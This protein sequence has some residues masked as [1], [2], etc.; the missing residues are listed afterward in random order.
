MDCLRSQLIQIQSSQLF[1]R[2]ESNS[3]SVNRQRR[4]LSSSRLYI[5]CIAKIIITR[6][7]DKNSRQKPRT[8][9]LPS[10]ETRKKEPKNESNMRTVRRGPPSVRRVSS[11]NSNIVSVQLQSHIIWYSSAS[12]PS[13]SSSA[14]APIFPRGL[15]PETPEESLL[16]GGK[17]C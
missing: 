6:H 15:L 17:L 3:D 16:F 10:L 2:V 1:F 14:S 12:T 9:A 4:L 13:A 8:R 7:L 11:S 5:V